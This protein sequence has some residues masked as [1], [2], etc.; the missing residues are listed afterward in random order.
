M[1]REGRTEGRREGK[2]GRGRAAAAATAALRGVVRLN[3][4]P[5]ASGPLRAFSASHHPIVRGAS[6]VGEVGKRRRGGEQGLHHGQHRGKA[7]NSRSHAN[8]GNR[9]IAAWQLSG[10]NYGAL[11]TT[12][13]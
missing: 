13:M 3:H 11:Y 4:A 12:S 10:W 6:H 5:S 8:F 9:C 1:G 2:S 7:Q